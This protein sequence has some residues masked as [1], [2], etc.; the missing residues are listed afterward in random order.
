MFRK[1]TEVSGSQIWINLKSIM[2]F[3]Y[4]ENDG[5]LLTYTNGDTQ[6]VKESP[7]EILDNEEL[8]TDQLHWQ[9]SN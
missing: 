8:R 9:S 3:K 1:L 7:W 6:Y 5:T 4:N 2:K